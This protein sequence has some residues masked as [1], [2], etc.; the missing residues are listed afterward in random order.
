MALAL[1]LFALVV[2]GGMVAG[3]F[4]VARLEQ[5]SGRN[6]RFAAEAAHGA[7]AGLW[8]RAELTPEVALS[9]P[10]GAA[11]LDLEPLLAGFGV[12]VER[13]LT[14]LADNLFLLQSRA[15]R[16]DAAGG[17]L[18]GHSVGLLLTLAN[19]AAGGQMLRP[20]GRRAWLQLY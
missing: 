16:H 13:K 14:R 18:A 12:V 6:V 10:I 15:I 19:D 8:E 9:L 4:F 20:I 5:Q 17:R 3:A 7:E 11:P 1:A 2:I